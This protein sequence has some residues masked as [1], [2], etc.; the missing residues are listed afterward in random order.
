V[1][2]TG[3]G[4][5]ISRRLAEL[6][7]GTVEMASELGR[8]TAMSLTL[9]LPVADPEQLSSDPQA[10]SDPMSTTT[11]PRRTAPS[12]AEAEAE[13]TLVLVADDH[14]TNRNLLVRQVNALGYAAE[15]VE[16]GAEALVRWK[17]GRFGIIITDC[18]MPEM[19]G[20]ELARSIRGFESNRPGNAGKRT[21]IL[22]CTAYAQDGEAETCLTSGMDDYLSKPVE[23]QQIQRKLDR[24]LPIPEVHLPPSAA[25]GNGKY[26]PTDSPVDH[27][28]LAA[29]L[30]GDAATER[31]V[32]TDF[33]HAN[34]KDA[35]MLERAVAANDGPQV[36]RATHR[37]LGASKMIG[38]HALAG[39][40]ERIGHAS[41]SRDWMAVMADMSAFHR[42]MA[43]LNTYVDAL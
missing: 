20:Y 25:A 31:D 35:A 8:G 13:G 32:L 37:I 42:E 12:I 29:V 33:R 9:S 21:P 4:L 28:V 14:P 27:A 1:A 7:G 18:N 38:A 15:S 39:V 10:A 3:L 41:R 30:G 23:L 6:M 22:A 5:S 17:T 34:D 40:C 43:R 16:N 26:A 24:W 36:T 2:G 11:S 19:D